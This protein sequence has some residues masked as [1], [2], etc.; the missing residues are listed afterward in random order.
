MLYRANAENIHPMNHP[1]VG[2]LVRWTWLGRLPGVVRTHVGVPGEQQL[3][4]FDLSMCQPRVTA[5]INGSDIPSTPDA[6]YHA[7]PLRG[8]GISGVQRESLQC[9]NGHAEGRQGVA[10]VR[11]HG[12]HP[13]E[14]RDGGVLV[15]HEFEGHRPYQYRGDRC[16]QHRH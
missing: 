5:R 1:V 14:L 10:E 11:R 12:A 3:C 6:L 15:S 9:L 13:A 4:D 7:M 2:R 8:V 16:C